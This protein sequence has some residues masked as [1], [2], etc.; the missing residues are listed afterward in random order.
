[1]HSAQKRQQDMRHRLECK[2][3]QSSAYSTKI[4]DKRERFRNAYYTLT[5]I[6]SN[7][8]R[9][10]ADFL[11]ITRHAESNAPSCRSG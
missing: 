9:F 8:S 10:I 6:G 3:M 2:N 11:G 1:V 5:I 7:F 4:V